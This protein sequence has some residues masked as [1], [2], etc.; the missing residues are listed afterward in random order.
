M[1]AEAYVF[2]ITTIFI[3]LVAPAY[4]FIAVT[5]PAPRRSS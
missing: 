2:L 3:G 5:P 4:W 1:R